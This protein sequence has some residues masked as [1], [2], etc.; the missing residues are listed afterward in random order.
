[1]T[2]RPAFLAFHRVYA[3]TRTVT[4][5][6]V[7]IPAVALGELVLWA[8]PSTLLVVGFRRPRGSRL[9]ATDASASYGFGVCAPPVDPDTHGTVSRQA[10]S[11]LTCVHIPN[12]Y[13]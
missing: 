12:E 4:D 3:F 7:D 11:S 9:V 1:M 8:S 6:E 10:R 5:D 13:G 2:S